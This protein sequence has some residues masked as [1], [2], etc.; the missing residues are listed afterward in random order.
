MKLKHTCA[1]LNHLKM[2]KRMQ[3]KLIAQVKPQL[4]LSKFPPPPATREAV[5]V[6]PFWTIFSP[7]LKVAD[8]Q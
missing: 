4:K 3:M 2:T 1:V 5:G 7:P 6:P 8:V